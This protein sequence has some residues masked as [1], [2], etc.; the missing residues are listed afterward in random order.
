ML[1]PGDI[2]TTSF[3]IDNNIT[4][5]TNVNGLA[6]DPLTARSAIVSY[7]IYRT[8]TTTPSGNAEVG[9]I[10]LIYD[11]SAPAGS[12]WLITQSSTGIAGVIF[13]ITDAGQ[14]TYKSTDIGAAGYSGVIKF[15]A[16]T[17]V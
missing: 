14:V 10:K 4:V 6:F 11:D 1:A 15:V 5:A 12:K 8:S 13:S 9:F 16:R 3:S 17:F 2:L 7:S